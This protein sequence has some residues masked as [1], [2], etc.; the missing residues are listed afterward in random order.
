[1]DFLLNFKTL[2]LLTYITS[3]LYIH[4]RGEVRLKFLR[5][6]TDHSALMAP[7]NAVMYLFSAVP[8]KPYLDL[9]DF[10][11]LKILKDNWKEIRTEAESLYQQGYI[12]ASDQ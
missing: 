9:A 11:E 2:C 6:L 12:A 5:Q 8:S 4:F 1:M 7:I 10:P 3:I